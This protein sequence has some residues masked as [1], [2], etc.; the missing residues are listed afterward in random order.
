MSHTT[1]STEGTEMEKEEH[2]VDTQG[3][4]AQKGSTQ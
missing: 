2:T 4:D 1:E 3:A